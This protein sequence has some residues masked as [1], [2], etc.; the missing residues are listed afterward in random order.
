MGHTYQG[1]DRVDDRLV[2]MDF[3]DY[4][5]IWLGGDMCSETTKNLSGIEHMDDIFDISSSNTHWA[6]GNHDIRNGNVNWITETT[7]R[8]TYYATYFD[9]ITLLVLNTNFSLYGY[10]DSVN[11]NA[12]FQLIQN[13]CDTIKKSSHLI[14]LSHHV[15]WGNIAEKTNVKRFTNVDFS[16]RMWL[17]YNPNLRYNDGVYPKL[18]EVRKRGV[19]VIHIAGD[20][21]QRSTSYKYLTQ[22]SIQFL[23]SGITSAIK[24]NEQFRTFGKPDSILIFR[25]DINKR[26]LSWRFEVLKEEDIN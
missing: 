23:G 9:G 2:E 5:Q 16:S 4:D 6:L 25:H 7:D 11:T 1:E 24:W 8:P 3:S 12:Q 15:C 26:K 19:K 20:F 14:L 13:V 10:N 21:G 22:D 17:N 18:K